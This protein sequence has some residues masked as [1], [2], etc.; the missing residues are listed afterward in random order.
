MNCN[1]SFAAAI[2]GCLSKRELRPPS[3][4]RRFSLR[5]RFGIGLPIAAGIWLRFRLGLSPCFRCRLILGLH[6]S[7]AV[8]IPAPIVN[9]GLAAEK[10]LFKR[11]E[12]TAKIDPAPFTFFQFNTTLPAGKSDRLLRPIK[13]ETE[14]DATT[15]RNDQCRSAGATSAPA[16]CPGPERSSS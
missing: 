4:C 12:R 5:T 15:P 2:G 9:T 11:L 7:I 16:C 1:S 6:H 13:P 10:V 3:I 14:D 8:Y